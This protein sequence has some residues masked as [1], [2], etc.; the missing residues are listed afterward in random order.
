VTTTGT[1]E[2]AL[3]PAAIR[4]LVADDEETVVDVL[5][6]LVGSD[7]SLRFVGAA[8]DAEQAIE[9]VVRERPDVVLLDVRMPGGGGMRAARE[10]SRRCPPTKIVALSAHEDADT[11]I[12][13]IGAGAHGYVPKGDS[14]D[15]I[16]RSIHRAVGERRPS[17]EEKPHLTLV[18]PLSRRDQRA[19]G[20]ARA[21]IGGAVT[22]EFGPIVDIG[23]G[24][25]VGLEVQPRVATLPHRSYDAWCADA[26]AVGV[27]MDLELAAF[28]EGRLALREL[29]DDI[30]LEF[31]M[32]P[33]TASEARFRRSIQKTVAHRIV[34]GFSPL[35]G[36]GGVRINDVDFAETLEGLRAR[37]IR[38]AATDAGT[39][40]SG[41]GHLTSLSPHYVRLDR[42]LTRS[43][44]RSFSN[45]SIVAAVVACAT[46]LGARVIAA[47]VTSEQQLEEMR[48]LGVHLVQGPHVGESFHLSELH[49][50][51]AAVGTPSGRAGS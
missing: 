17:H 46:Q 49:D 4:V 9:M 34:L 18:A 22:T 19:A 40:L 43:V 35:V 41:L 5:R 32:S 44:D 42:T 28:R 10:I 47:G 26:Q 15:K 45:H 27:L 33:F 2:K 3:D 29:P 39:G 12:G 11:V 8:N 7:P 21:I 13:M 6:A 20:V 30:F 50:R 14:T 23:T 37:G 25:M 36:A 31:E 51:V 48:R 1:S 24:R 38:V 16:L